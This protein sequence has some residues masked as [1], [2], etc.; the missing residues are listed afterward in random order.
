[1]WYKSSMRTAAIRTLDYLLQTL[2]GCGE[3]Y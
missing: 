3:K 1:M 2:Q